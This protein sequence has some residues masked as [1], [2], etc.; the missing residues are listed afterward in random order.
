[1]NLI[2]KARLSAK[3]FHM[4]ISCVCIS[5]KTNVHNKN[6]ALSLAFIMRF[7]ATRKWPILTSDAIV[8]LVNFTIFSVP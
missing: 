4:K 8:K 5:M 1:M 7:K 6:V 3:L 2:M